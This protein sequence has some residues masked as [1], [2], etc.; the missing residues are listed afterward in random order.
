VIDELCSFRVSRP[1]VTD[2]KRMGRDLAKL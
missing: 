1:G 2:A